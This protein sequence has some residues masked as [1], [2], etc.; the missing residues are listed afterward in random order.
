M[1]ASKNYP[2]IGKAAFEAFMALLAILAV[3]GVMGFL[4]KV[5]AL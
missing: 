2:H 4:R 3:L 1:A 5:G